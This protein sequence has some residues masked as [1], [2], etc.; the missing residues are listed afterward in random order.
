MLHPDIKQYLLAHPIHG[1]PRGSKH[2]G[3]I[4]KSIA[5]VR[6]YRSYETANPFSKENQEKNKAKKDK[7]A[8]RAAASQNY[9]QYEHISKYAKTY[10]TPFGP[11]IHEQLK[12]VSH[13]LY[14][15]EY[16]AET[17]EKVPDGTNGEKWAR[18]IDKEWKRTD[19]PLLKRVR[20]TLLDA[21]HNILYPKD[22]QPQMYNSLNAPKAYSKADYSRVKV[23]FE[24]IIEKIHETRRTL[25][26]AK[27]KTFNAENK[28]NISS[29]NPAIELNEV[30]T[31]LLR[32]LAVLSKFLYY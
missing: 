17:M 1:N 15:L 9:M 14:R 4:A 24:S 11:I 3:N 13:I 10:L 19:I 12:I 32:V 29:I 25:F 28:I 23:F 22:K 5:E 8:A 31:Q 18:A 30:D 7:I 20:Q 21:R 6:E 26:E 27:K 2:V 16:T